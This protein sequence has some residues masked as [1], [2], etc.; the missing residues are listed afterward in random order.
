MKLPSSSFTDECLQFHGV[1]Q[2]NLPPE[3]EAV[4]S[5]AVH[6]EHNGWQENTY[7]KLVQENQSYLLERWHEHFGH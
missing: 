1:I 3:E 7:W 6:E 4:A 2:Y 5:V